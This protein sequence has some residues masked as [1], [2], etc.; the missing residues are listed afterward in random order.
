MG[1]DLTLFGAQI[2]AL[3][4]IVT[5]LSN[6]REGD[7]HLIG[8][9]QGELLGL[10]DRASEAGCSRLELLARARGLTQLLVNLAERDGLTFSHEMDRL[11]QEFD[12]TGQP[13]TRRI[14]L[15]RSKPLAAFPKEP[16]V[17]HTVFVDEAGVPSFDEC[18]NPCCA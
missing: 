1:M 13:V 8:V 9:Y 5:G 3:T 10:I 4:Q 6:I 2:D 16:P 7:D 14:P 15:S 18:L 11:V 12:A 17:V